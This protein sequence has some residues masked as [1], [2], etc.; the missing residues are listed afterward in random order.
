MA[1][2]TWL[3]KAATKVGNFVKKA[4]PVAKKVITSLAPGLSTVAGMIP[5]VGGAV[6]KG[7][8]FLSKTAQDDGLLDKIQ[9][10]AQNPD[11]TLRRAM[12]R[13]MNKNVG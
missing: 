9:V 4:I 10:G 13:L 1:F 5:G 3:K 8:D 11:E 2:G 12:S 6:S 7:I